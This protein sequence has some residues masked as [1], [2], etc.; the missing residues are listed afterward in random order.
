MSISLSEYRNWCDLLL[1]L[2]WRGR[3][4]AVACSRPPPPP[5][6]CSVGSIVRPRAVCMCGIVRPQGPASS[7]HLTPPPRS[8]DPLAAARRRRARARRDVR[9][10]RAEGREQAAR[11]VQHQGESNDRDRSSAAACVRCA[12]SHACETTN[13][14]VKR[15]RPRSARTRSAQS[16]LPH[17]APRRAAT[18]PQWGG[19][20]LSR[21]WRVSSHTRPWAVSSRPPRTRAR[22]RRR[23]ARRFASRVV[24]IACGVG[25][26]GTR[27]RTLARAGRRRALRGNDDGRRTTA[28]RPTAA[29]RPVHIRR[30]RLR[31]GAARG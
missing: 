10:V 26:S 13:L 14:R 31:E 16:F 5:R 12:R 8:Q 1:R 15:T 24:A 22:P 20:R 4:C 2:L 6:T 27:V 30:R 9:L 21:S 3:A 17:P 28:T 29:V 18:K 7:S 11:R 23:C 19:W 25:A